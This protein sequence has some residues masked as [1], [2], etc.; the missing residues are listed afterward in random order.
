MLTPPTLS[1]GAQV[2]RRVDVSDAV[3]LGGVLEPIHTNPVII[4]DEAFLGSRSIVVEGV[5]VGRRAVLAAGTVLTASTPII[6]VRGSEPHVMHGSVPP[7]V[8]VIPGSWPKVFPAGTY[9]V[10]CALIVGGRGD[11]A[12]QKTRLNP[13]LREFPLLEETSAKGETADA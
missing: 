7:G 1:S 3:G 5:R 12:N 9:D 6:D 10:P 13:N 2:A 8:V 4:E 11:S